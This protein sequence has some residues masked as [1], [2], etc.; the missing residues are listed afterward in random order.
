[1]RGIYLI[2]HAGPGGTGRTGGAGAEPA[3]LHDRASRSGWA[4]HESVLA[5]TPEEG[6]D[7]ER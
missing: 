4:L 7:V 1:M 6:G 5:L 3:P 2:Y